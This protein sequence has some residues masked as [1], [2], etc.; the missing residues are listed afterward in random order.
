MSSYTYLGL[1]LNSQEGFT[2]AIE[3][4]THKGRKAI[5]KIRSLHRYPNSVQQLHS[6]RLVQPIITYNA[7]IWFMDTVQKRENSKKRARK[8]ERHF[9]KL[10]SVDETPF[11]KLHSHFIKSSLMTHQKTSTNGCRQEVGRSVVECTILIQS[12]K[13]GSESPN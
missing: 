4:L 2:K 3:A 9:D 10:K 1:D 8:N 5:F 13:T 11:E 6:N 7:E 12:I